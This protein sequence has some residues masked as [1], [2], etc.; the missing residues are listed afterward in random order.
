MSISGLLTFS[1]LYSRPA[2]T[3]S[4]QLNLSHTERKVSNSVTVRNNFCSV[5]DPDPFALGPPGSGSASQYGS[6]FGSFYHHDK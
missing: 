4:L 2:V 1:T 5:A 3:A 6:G